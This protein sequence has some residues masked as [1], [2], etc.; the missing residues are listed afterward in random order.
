MRRAIVFALCVVVA[1]SWATALD[2]G[3]NIENLAGY[4]GDEAE[5]ERLEETARVSLWIDEML[6]DHLLFEAQVSYAYSLDRAFL[7]DADRLALNGRI[8]IE[9]GTLTAVGFDL[10]RFSASDVSG[11]VFAHNVDGLRLQLYMPDLYVN[12]TGGYTGYVA[13]GNSDITMTQLDS[14][15]RDDDDVYFSPP[16]LVTSAELGF[17]ELLAR[18]TI[19]LTYLGQFDFRP[20]GDLAED[21]DTDQGLVGGRLSTHY[22]GLHVSGPIGSGVYHDLFGFAAIGD[23]LS[24]RS[25]DGEF[26]E[27]RL[28]GYLAGYGIRWYAPQLL[29]S[30]LSVRFL[31]ASGDEDATGS[32]DGNQDGNATAF[33][34]VSTTTFGLVFNPPLTNL[35][36]GEL[37]YSI[38]PLA[39]SST[40]RTD[41]L[42]TLF[43]LGLFFRTSLGTLSEAG[44]LPASSSYYL[45]SEL[46]LLVNVR[47]FSDLGF[48]VAVGAFLPASD[49][50]ARDP[51]A[52]AQVTAS[53]RF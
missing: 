25:D 52:A 39:N 17:P 38:K 14:Q 23:S 29:A 32:I 33:V 6:G 8:P 22:P 43:R 36:Y 27:A 49:A 15:D 50:F 11:Y 46:N 51:E 19:T 4:A 3:G 13:K 10:G 47:P 40:L 44:F 35:A 41:Q 1:A 12:L 28:F 2:Y 20:T 24:Y 7:L 5:G 34:P 18:H 53:L 16:R 48:S 9:G 45:G 37:T 26:A 42:Q 21:G 30:S 31:Y